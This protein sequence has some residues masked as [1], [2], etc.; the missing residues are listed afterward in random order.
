MLRS[1]LLTP[2]FAVGTW[3]R[4]FVLV[5]INNFITALGMMAFLPLFPLYLQELGITS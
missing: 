2:W 5:W 1:T 4:N 3:R